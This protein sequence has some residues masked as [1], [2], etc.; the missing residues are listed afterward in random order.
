M[1]LLKVESVI[2]ETD[3]W[4]N[5]APFS[6][7]PV[8]HQSAWQQVA[9]LRGNA[10]ECRLSL[11]DAAAGRH[12][13]SRGGS[14]LHRCRS[15]WL[16]G[17]ALCSSEGWFMLL[18]RSLVLCGC[19]LGS[20]SFLECQRGADRGET[21]W[22]SSKWCTLVW[23]LMTLAGILLLHRSPKAETLWFVFACTLCCE[24]KRV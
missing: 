17:G 5:T 14:V 19:P 6:L 13:G 21:D 10:T 23:A 1:H 8:F 24:I 7:T 11:L 18:H 15:R 22:G 20:S 4:T 9:F 12:R 3:C 16:A 2:P